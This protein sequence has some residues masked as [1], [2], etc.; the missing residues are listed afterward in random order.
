MDRP[1]GN[2]PVHKRISFE[3]FAHG[4]SSSEHRSLGF[5]VRQRGNILYWTGTFNNAQCPPHITQTESLYTI[6][7]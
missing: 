1:L 2:M 4:P 7:E 3:L 6:V 5:L